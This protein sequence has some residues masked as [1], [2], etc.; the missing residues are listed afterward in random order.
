MNITATAGRTPL[1]RLA[2][3]APEG[4]EI[5][6]KVEARNPGG[7]VKDRVALAIVDDAERRGLLPPGG[8]IVEATSGNTGIGLAWVAAARGYRLILT[9]PEDM[10]V[11][12]QNLLR[13]L[14]A[15]LHLTPAIE[16]MGGAVFAAEELAKEPSAFLAR[17]FENP[18]NAD[19]HYRG[20]GPEILDQ[21]GGRVDAF[22]AG[23][24]T[25]GTLTGAG[26]ALRE[27]LPDVHIVAVEPATCAVLSGG[28]PGFTRILGLG[29]GFVPGVLDRSLIDEVV[30]VADDDAIAWSLRLAKEEGILAGFSSGAAVWAAAKVAAAMPEGSR[31]VTVL[32]DTGERYLSM[33][34]PDAVALAHREGGAM[35]QAGRR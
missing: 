23:V 8:T 11:E 18:A 15:E 30:T 35:R 31:V 17:Q 19:A 2:R 29:A 10:S 4:R 24:G 6:A 28:R 25:G 33:V 26:R 13:W 22:V 27:E 3:L 1:V 5:L 34:S 14:G 20:T 16:G 7:S 9:M 32:P 21:A 12:R